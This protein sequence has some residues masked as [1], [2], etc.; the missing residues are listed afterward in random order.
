[1]YIKANVF[2]ADQYWYFMTHVS[3]HAERCSR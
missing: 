3:E 1:M 2:M